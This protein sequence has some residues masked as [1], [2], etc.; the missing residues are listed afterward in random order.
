MFRLFS[1]VFAVSY[2]PI[3]WHQSVTPLSRKKQ[4]VALCSEKEHGNRRN[5]SFLVKKDNF[6]LSN[7]PV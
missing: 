2:Q 1:A 3:L 4:R 5:A 6:L 7:A